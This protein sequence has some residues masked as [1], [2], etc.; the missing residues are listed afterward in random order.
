[1]ATITENKYDNKKANK[2]IKFCRDQKVQNLIMYLTKRT[3]IYFDPFLSR[4]KAQVRAC[5]HGS[6]CS[7]AHHI[8]ELDI[9]DHILE[10]ENKDMKDFNAIPGY[11]NM[12]DVLKKNKSKVSTEDK[13]LIIKVLE[14]ENFIEVLNLWID[15]S[16]R[17]HKIKNDL[18]DK[19]K[20]NGVYLKR[21]RWRGTKP[22]SNSSTYQFP[23]DVPKFNFEDEDIWWAIQRKFKM[24]MKAEECRNKVSKILEEFN[25]EKN[26][27]TKNYKKNKNKNTLADLLGFALMDIKKKNQLFVFNMCD[28]ETNCKYGVHL[29]KDQIC[30]QDFVEG[31]CSC[32]NKDLYL[33][34]NE[35]I[36]EAKSLDKSTLEYKKISKKISKLTSE[37]NK[38]MIHYTER[39]MMPILKQIHDHKEKQ[40]EIVE[41]K[42]ESLKK[43]MEMLDEVEEDLEVSDWDF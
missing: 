34:L 3:G 15:L 14:K 6:N 43:E 30:V 27:I 4:N 13:N 7:K 1:M 23:E 18:K 2:K 12:L 38:V 28:L 25:V 37:V 22:P 26:K 32:K 40:K 36:D 20:D 33:K 5:P 41:K 10:L 24:C 9:K 42:K 39:G 8:S 11:N 31:K 16:T 21:N 19:A 35:L 17:Y 29:K